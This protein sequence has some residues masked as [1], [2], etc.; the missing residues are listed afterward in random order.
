MDFGV[1]HLIAFPSQG[2]TLFPGDL[3][4]TGTSFGLG[5]GMKPPVSPNDGDVCEAELQG[6]GVILN[7]IRAVS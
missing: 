4:A 1:A 6:H 2:I 5:L 7:R 3:I